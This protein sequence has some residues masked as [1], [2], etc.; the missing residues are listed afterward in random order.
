[1]SDTAFGRCANTRLPVCE[2]L[3]AMAVERPAAGV[4][5]GAGRHTRTAGKDAVTDGGERRRWQQRLMRAGDELQQ[6][7]PCSGEWVTDERRQHRAQEE[8]C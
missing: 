4:G 2:P 3:S 1:M 5:N 6:Q 8:G 7:Q